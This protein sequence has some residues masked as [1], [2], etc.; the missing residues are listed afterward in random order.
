MSGVEP[1]R[2]DAAGEPALLRQQDLELELQGPG[3]ADPR[4]L[5]VLVRG[6]VE[7]ERDAARPE[8]LPHASPDRHGPALVGRGFPIG[9]D[10]RC[11]DRIPAVRDR[12]Q[13][14]GLDEE[15]VHVGPSARAGV[16]PDVVHQHAGK[17]GAVDGDRDHGGPGAVLLSAQIVLGRG[18]K[19]KGRP[20]SPAEAAWSCGR[21]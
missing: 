12:V 6:D 2:R 16:R 7:I 17:P 4:V 10:D 3:G 14:E 18:R 11:G 21:G 9:R 1:G 15:L 5:D 8:C 13:R 20:H 19:E